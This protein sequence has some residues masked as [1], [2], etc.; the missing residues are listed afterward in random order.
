MTPPLSA[1]YQYIV[2]ELAPT[3]HAPDEAPVSIVCEPLNATASPPA[4]GSIILH[5]EKG[6]TLEEAQAIAKTLQ[7]KVKGLFH[8]KASPDEVI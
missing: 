5:L 7:T 1:V 2:R 4:Q 6:T 8:L 3:E